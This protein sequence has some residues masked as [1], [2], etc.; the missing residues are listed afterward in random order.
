MG[1][2]ESYTSRSEHDHTQSYDS[3]GNGPATH[4]DEYGTTTYDRYQQSYAGE[5][6]TG[7]DAYGN[8]TYGDDNY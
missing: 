2:E 6:A 5:V 8:P 1:A 4:H 3:Y 7:R